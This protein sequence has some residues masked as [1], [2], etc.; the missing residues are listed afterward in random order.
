MGVVR[1]GKDEIAGA[2]GF[3]KASQ[4]YSTTCS[5]VHPREV[6][7]W[8]SASDGKNC[9]TISSDV[10]VFDWIDPTTEGGGSAILQPIL[11][12][13]RKSCHS[14]GNYY[15]QPGDHSYDFS[16]YSN[17]GD[18]KSGYR[19]GTQSNQPLKVVVSKSVSD[20]TGPETMSFISVG[21]KNLILSTIKKCDD[22]DNLIIR[23]YDIEGIDSEAQI[24]VSS[25]YK[26][27]E[28]TNMIEEDGKA[29][30]GNGNT[31]N[32]RVGHNAIETVKLFVR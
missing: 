29:I 21:N 18:W 27:A 24:S 11:L 10:S 12:A 19:S 17:S 31:L 26:K 7:D 20:G 22:D 4:I 2:A 15:L 3:S 30:S 5:E 32:L 8:F 9:L 16:I 13:S 28:L 6:Q 23:C 25:A 14:E 1:V